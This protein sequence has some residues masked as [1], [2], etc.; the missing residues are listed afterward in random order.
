VNG[1]YLDE[2]EKLHGELRD[3]FEE[4]EKKFCREGQGTMLLLTYLY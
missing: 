2:Y 1:I 4:E 3:A